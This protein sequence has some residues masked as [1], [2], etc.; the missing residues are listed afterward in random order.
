MATDET[1]PQSSCERP[2]S[3]DE[4]RMIREDYEF[5]MR[6]EVIDAKQAI[7]QIRAAYGL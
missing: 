1:N 6:G 3:D 4:L 7:A 2:L 5:A